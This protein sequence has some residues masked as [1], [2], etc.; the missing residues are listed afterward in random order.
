MPDSNLFSNYRSQSSQA[1]KALGPIN[2]KSDEF[3]YTSL[4]SFS[5]EKHSSDKVSKL[6]TLKNADEMFPGVKIIRL[7][8]SS[9]EVEVHGDL[10]S[11]SARAYSLDHMGSDFEDLLQRIGPVPERLQSDLFANW[12]AGKSSHEI[13]IKVE[14]NAVIEE[15]IHI[16]HRL[17]STLLNH[18]VCVFVE[19]GAQC[20]IVEEYRM[21]NEPADAKGI[22]P[23]VSSLVQVYAEQNS[24]LSWVQIQK[25]PDNVTSVMRTYVEAADNAKVEG[26]QICLGSATSHY[27]SEFN[28][29]GKGSEIDMICAFQGTKKRHCD[30]FVRNS[31]PAPNTL[32]CTRVINVV[33]DESTA[34]FNGMIE[35][36][37]N[38]P[39]ADA[40]HAAKSLVLSGKATIQSN[41]KLE[42]ST[43]DVKCAHG[44]SISSIDPE[45]LYYLQSRG[46]SKI[47]AESIIVNSFMNPA[48]DRISIEGVRSH[49]KG[50]VSKNRLSSN[51]DTDTEA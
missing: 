41:P 25:M 38:A 2:I 37:K 9:S 46:I 4:D 44:S 10:L 31:H 43:D 24:N 11:G 30:F 19:E 42:I 16:I 6:V 49:Y 13:L 20:S 17:D 21:S 23:Q 51:L 22:P 50:L 14:K 8:S 48:L 15:P 7:S 18:R 5:F 40:T 33:D 34:V 27:H 35:I 45:Q 39:G 47:D 28:S 36:P 32:S 12:V 3:K 1:Y 29:V 26:A